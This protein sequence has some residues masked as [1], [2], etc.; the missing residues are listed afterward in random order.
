MENT[1]KIKIKFVR[2]ENLLEV[3]DTFRSIL[4]TCALWSA[5]CSK[6]G[7]ANVNRSEKTRKPPGPLSI[8]PF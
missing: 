7:W 3:F 2:V 1:T 6:D 5:S 8:V 4:N